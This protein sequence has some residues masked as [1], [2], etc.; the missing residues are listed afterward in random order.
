MTNFERYGKTWDKKD[1]TEWFSAMD[2]L[3]SNLFS[4]PDE[5][6]E[7][8]IKDIGFCLYKNW[9]FVKCLDGEIVFGN[10]VIPAI[11]KQDFDNY[12]PTNLN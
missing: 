11:T 3:S 6:E 8:Y 9:K 4:F 7:G 5:I 12:R 10:M 2:W 1:C